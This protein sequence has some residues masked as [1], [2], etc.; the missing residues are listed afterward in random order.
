MFDI[1][2]FPC[3]QFGSLEPANNHEILNCLKYVYPGDGFEPNFRI[4]G[5]LFT[6]G[7]DEHPLFRFLKDRCPSPGG[8]IAHQYTLSWQP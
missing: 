6:N 7:A 8:F 3:H 1:A 2:A 4:F 5:K